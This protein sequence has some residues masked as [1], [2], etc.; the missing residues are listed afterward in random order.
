MGGID[1]FV[2]PRKCSLCSGEGV[3]LDTNMMSHE[4]D[5]PYECYQCKG[6]G[7]GPSTKEIKTWKDCSDK[8]PNG[9]KNY[10]KYHVSWM[11]EIGN[12]CEC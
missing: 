3:L 5:E 12:R 6:T 10:Q 11:M 1:V 7:K 8:L 2:V 9:D 4:F